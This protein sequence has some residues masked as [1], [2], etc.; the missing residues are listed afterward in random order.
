MSYESK[1]IIVER[2]NFE[3]ASSFGETIAEL[4]LSGMPNDFFPIEKTFEKEIECPI[5]MNGEL[6]NKDKYDKVLRYT[7]VEK[8]LKVLYKC[9]AKEHYRRTELAI[10]ALKSF[11]KDWYNIA[12]VHYGY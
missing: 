7:S 12:I 8:L 10:N 6:V 9:E 1:L 2:W 5:Y 11:Q 4:N 3:G